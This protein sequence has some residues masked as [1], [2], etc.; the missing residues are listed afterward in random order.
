MP[1][2]VTAYRADDASERIGQ[3]FLAREFR[4]RDGAPA[5]FVSDALVELLECIRMELGS[6]PLIVHSGYRTPDHNRRVGG[7]A[8]SYHMSGV[9]AD[10]SVAGVRPALLASVARSEG[11]GGVG[12]YAAF[13]HVDIAGRRDW[14]G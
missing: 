12:L 4:C 8:G 6:I 1:Y 9:A 13:V 3:H 2:S 10:I 11:A 14:E 7:A 5:W